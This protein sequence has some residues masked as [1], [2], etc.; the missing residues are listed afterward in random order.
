MTELMHVLQGGDPFAAQ[1]QR[2]KQRYVATST[3]MA[4]TLA[5]N[6]VGLPRLSA[7]DV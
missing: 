5:E 7:D 3:A 1:I 4:R 6:Y 2:A